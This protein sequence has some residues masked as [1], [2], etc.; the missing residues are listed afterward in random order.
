M[1]EE[2]SPGGRPTRRWSVSWLATYRWLAWVSF[3]A[4]LAMI[5]V[6]VLAIVFGILLARDNRRYQR[7]NRDIRDLRR[8]DAPIGFSV[9]KNVTQLAEDDVLTILTGWSTAGGF[10]AYDETDGGFDPDTGFFTVALAA[11]YMATGLVC[12]DSSENGT[13]T[14]GLANSNG[15][16]MG[17][18]NRVL[19]ISGI[20]FQCM[21]VSQIMMLDVG[22]TVHLNALS[23]SGNN[24]TLATRSRFSI[25]RI[26]QPI[27]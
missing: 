26:A 12:F 20:T 14:G 15:G 22:D 17:V 18:F 21:G 9:H 4:H 23:N 13:R 16:I 10:P 7:L 3:L 5:G 19:G 8:A 27:G 11:K 6:I 1:F 25:E 2:L 24:E